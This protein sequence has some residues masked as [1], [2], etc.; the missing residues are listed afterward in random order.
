MDPRNDF[1]V[2][3]KTPHH[4]HDFWGDVLPTHRDDHK[5]GLMNSS[6]MKN[7]RTGR[8]A[9]DGIDSKTANR[10]YIFNIHI[11]TGAGDTVPCEFFQCPAAAMSQPDDNGSSRSD[12]WHWGVGR[13]DS[14][15][16]VANGAGAIGSPAHHAPFQRPGKFGHRSN[17]SGAGHP[18]EISQIV[19][20]SGG[21]GSTGAENFTS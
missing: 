3:I 15:G 9:V 12:D 13:G 6:R 7:V 14:L 17:K 20:F 16:G 2:R 19:K 4:R 8:I 18:R 5:K 10:P 21:A 1:S 11:H